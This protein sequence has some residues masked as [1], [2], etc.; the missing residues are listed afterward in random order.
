MESR[1]D[2]DWERT[3]S[4]RYLKQKFPN[5]DRR[6]INKYRHEY[7]GNNKITLSKDEILEIRKIVRWWK[8]ILK[9]PIKEILPP[10]DD[11]E[12]QTFR[13][14]KEVTNRIREIS[15]KNGLSISDIVNHLIRRFI[16]DY[17]TQE[18]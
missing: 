4:E 1:P 6:L 18:K 15:K 2:I 13:I 9:N 14:E 16:A 5:A 7:I 11:R 3:E 10:K 8:S 12:N 17:E